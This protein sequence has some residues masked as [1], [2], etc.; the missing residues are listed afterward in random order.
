MLLQE[1]GRIMAFDTTS[2]GF[3]DQNKQYTPLTIMERGLILVGVQGLR[4]TINPNTLNLP[5]D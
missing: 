2:G 1:I 4:L 3:W 5:L